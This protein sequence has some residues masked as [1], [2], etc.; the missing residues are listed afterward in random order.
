MPP[1]VALKTT[2]LYSIFCIRPQ[3]PT[4]LFTFALARSLMRL[5]LL[6]VLLD[7]VNHLI[8]GGCCLFEEFCK[9]TALIL[10]WFLY[11]SVPATLSPP[12]LRFVHCLYLQGSTDR[13]IERFWTRFSD[14]HPFFPVFQRVDKL[15]LCKAV[16]QIRNRLGIRFTDESSQRTSEDR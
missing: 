7:E 13:F 9:C 12:R 15:I 6:L 5:L 4:V 8:Y 1:C 16:L 2:A 10:G 14:L 11:Y 3:S